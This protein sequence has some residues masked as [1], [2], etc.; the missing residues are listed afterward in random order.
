MSTDHREW[1]RKQRAFRARFVIAYG[2][3]YAADTILLA[4]FAAVGTVLPWIPIAYG[5]AGLCLCGVFYSIQISGAS[6]R[7]RDPYLT[8]F[9]TF[10]SSAVMLAFLGFAPQIGVFFL[11]IL[12]IVLGF[13]SLR[14]S[15]REAL[16]CCLAISAGTGAVTYHTP[17]ISWLPNS[18]SAELCLAW[19][20]Y[21]LTLA[22]LLGLGLV[23]NSMRT[24]LVKRKRQL[25]ESVRALETLTEELRQAKSE[26]E[27]ANAAKSRFLANMSHEIRTPMN[28]VLGMSELLLDAGLNETQRRY[29][30]TIRSSGEALLRIINDILDFSKIEAGRL[31]LDLVE[32][33]LRKLS[34]E[35]LQLL[36]STAH[37]KGLELTC[38][39]GPE[40]P[41]VVRADP[42]R[43]RQ[44]L[45][46]LLGNAVKFTERGEVTLAIERTADF[47]PDSEPRQCEL[48]FSISDTGIG[49]SP[50][51]QTRL[52]QVFSQAD[53]STTRRYG[54][55]GLGLAVSKQLAALMGGSIGVDSAPGRGSAFWFTIRAHVVELRQPAPV[56]AEMNGLRVL[57]V[58]DNATNRAILLH[59]VMAL[60]AVCELA[61]DG[62]AGL[63]A[64]RA[65]HVRGTPF[66]LA[67]IDMKMPRMNGLELMRAVRADPALRDTRLALLTSVSAAGEAAATRAAGA[68]AYLTKPVR[69]DELFNTLARLT[70]AAIAND[71]AAGANT[72]ALDCRGARVLLAED[73]LVNQEIACAMLES[74]GCLVTTAVD[75]RVA[76]DQWR[77]HRFALVLMDYQ[78]PTLDGLEATRAIRAQETAGGPRVPI[79]A[80]TANAMQGDRESCLAAGMDDYLPKP[81]KR[82][83]LMAVL[84]RWVDLAPLPA[85]APASGNDAPSGRPSTQTA[86]D[87]AAFQNALPAGMGVDS[88]LARKLIRLFIGESAK[89]VTEI[90]RAAAAADTQALFH[91]AHSLKSSAASVG[92]SALAGIAKELEALARAGHSA[93]LAERPAR[94]RPVHA[95]F[96]D[97]PAIRDLLTPETIDRNAA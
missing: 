26:A 78:M 73:N 35:A 76:V 77:A 36:A 91:A 50:E 68:D 33:D 17:G 67:L 28:G 5:L 37:E 85:A 22:R 56:R 64:L 92:A 87:P 58:E 94:L 34:E 25:K 57:I 39:I 10:A 66:H 4:L 80:L 13:G 65:A 23:G 8:I 70:G 1:Q 59:Q 89:Q 42:V 75:G 12:L 3:S 46:N 82:N 7:S 15:W 84:R 52:F 62:L 54:G 49:I 38:R 6:E 95:R 43:L 74:A 47:T 69:R 90:E 86:F 41:Q 81:F 9:Q 55:T 93:A 61:V 18:S 60:G 11:S 2:L 96:C 21:S 79:V 40:V 71:S 97:D 30:Q 48:R 44:I 53:C 14:L 32:V 31:D 19:V 24:A 20:W 27:S 29:A 88:P 83:E 45:L 72:D 51:A 16:L 63:E